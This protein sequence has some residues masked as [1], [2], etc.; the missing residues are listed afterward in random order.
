M[1]MA[2]NNYDATTCVWVGM[3]FILKKENMISQL[4][5]LA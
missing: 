2:Y 4:N 3:S 5:A 1:K